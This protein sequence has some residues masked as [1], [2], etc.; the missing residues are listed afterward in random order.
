MASGLI[1]YMRCC[2]RFST[3]TK[4]ASRNIFRCCEIAGALTEKLS[5]MSVADNSPIL[6]SSSMMPRLVGSASA[7]NNCCLAVPLSPC[8]PD[9]V[10]SLSRRDSYP[11]FVQEFIEAFIGFVDS[12]FR[13]TLEHSVSVSHG[14]EDSLNVYFRSSTWQFRESCCL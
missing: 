8:I 5:H 4:C 7:L 12:L 3:R 1:W 13:S 11:Y 14:L 10:I 2:A 6:A 9:V